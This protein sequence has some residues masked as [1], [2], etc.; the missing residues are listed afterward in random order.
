MLIPLE[1]GDYFKYF[2]LRGGGGGGGGIK[3]GGWGGGG[4]GG[5]AGVVIQGRRFRIEGM[6][7]FNRR[8]Q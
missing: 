7:H 2:R 8:R 5:G 1:G 6:I 4:G 3:G